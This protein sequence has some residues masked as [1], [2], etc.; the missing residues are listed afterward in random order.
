MKVIWEPK[1]IQC[2]RKYTREGLSETWM[3]GFLSTEEGAARYVSISDQDGM[4]TRA[5]TKES[6]AELLTKNDY[7]PREICGA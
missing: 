1:D 5:E 4:I 2:G 3:I 6:M 7:L